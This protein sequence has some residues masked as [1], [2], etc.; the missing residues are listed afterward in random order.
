ML[1]VRTDCSPTAARA[2]EIYD[3]ISDEQAAETF[4]TALEMGV[5][6]FDVA[7]SYGVGLAE[8]R[9]GRALRTAADQ[10]T[11][12]HVPRSEVF[13]STKVSR[14]LVPDRTVTPNTMDH[15][16][17]HGWAGGL[18]GFNSVIDLT[19]EGFM[20]QHTESLQRMGQPYVDGLLMHSQP[21]PGTEGWEQ[22]TSGGGFRAMEEL[23]DTG[24]VRAIGTGGG[25]HDSIEAMLEHCSIDYVCLPTSYTLLGQEVHDDGTM[26]LAMDNE[27]G[28]VIFAPFVS[29]SNAAWAVP[30]TLTVG[31]LLRTERR[32]PRRRLRRSRE[33]L[34]VRTLHL[35]FEKLKINGF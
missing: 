23:R 16:D 32:H 13:L 19:Y 24:A 7:P 6:Y 30:T 20:T 12:F 14:Q 15:A 3:R 4:E 28:V 26:Q 9:I 33:P 5:R 18:T 31:P 17:G 10:P 27:I 34:K 11:S 25:T 1:G 35:F 22:L 8:Q 29:V 2:G 21:L